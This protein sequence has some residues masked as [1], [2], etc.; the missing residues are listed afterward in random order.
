M[1]YRP[2]VDGLR[3][4][5][6]LWVL[7]F[8]FFP[9]CFPGG[10]TGVDLFFVISGFLI[11]RKIC[12]QI[13]LGI[14][15]LPQFYF[16][17]ARRLLPP[18]VLVLTVTLVI[19]WFTLLYDEYLDLARQTLAGLLFFP[20]LYSLNRA[21]YFIAGS[22]RLM[23]HLWSL[24]IEEQ[25]YLVWPWFLLLGRRWG[26]TK[27][28]IAALIALS[29]ALCSLWAVPYPDRAFLNPLSRIWELAIGGW[30]ALREDSPLHPALKRWASPLALLLLFAALTF[31]LAVNPW[32]MAMTVGCGAWLI[33]Y[34]AT[35]A[36]APLLQNRFLRRLGRISYGWYLWHWPL[37]IFA[38]T[39]RQPL[40][41]A[42]KIVILLLSYGVAEATHWLLEMP[43]VKMPV[44]RQGRAV[45]IS[46]GLALILLAF[47][48]AV[49]RTKILS[50]LQQA[51]QRYLN[52]PE[53]LGVDPWSFS[54][55]EP[56]F[57]T[58]RKSTPSSALRCTEIVDPAKPTV[59]LI[60][61]SLAAYLSV[62][63]RPLLK[64]ANANLVELS[65]LGCLPFSTEKNHEC[66]EIGRYIE[67]AVG[68]VKPDVL[69]LFVNHFRY[70]TYRGYTEPDYFA[71]LNLRLRHFERYVGRSILLLGQTPLWEDKLTRIHFRDYVRRRLE[72]PERTF[73]K[74]NERSLLTDGRMK[75]LENGKVHFFSLKEN[76]C[77]PEGCLTKVG[78]TRKE[79][80]VYDHVHLS[81]AGASFV[82]DRLMPHIRLASRGAF[83]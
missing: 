83:P 14:F 70:Y 34:G 44:Q 76:L 71:M 48:G 56:C 20:N 73:R 30:L 33:R 47:S 39:L 81:A 6:L 80:I 42:E 2:H 10:F 57:M 24:G 12:A 9:E 41:P 18:L 78:K 51:S 79:L 72:F 64:K 28:M 55:L 46:A 69:I 63:L 4:I 74:L 49:A 38:Q 77:T 7:G 45:A 23:D 26:I 60:G 15:S 19:G 50:P 27:G 31:R 37:L 65:S 67:E 25:Y 40:G 17:R 59:M 3:A 53:T 43:L 68:K 58:T 66:R 35:S 54:K 62:G 32:L 82:S 11:T 5:A 29:F 52:A 8:H 61:D 22:P 13:N 36:V 1:T 75:G 21:G 16:S